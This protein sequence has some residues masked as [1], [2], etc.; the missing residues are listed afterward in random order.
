VVPAHTRG[1]D[2]RRAVEALLPGCSLHGVRLRLGNADLTDK[3]DVIAPSSGPPLEIHVDGFVLGGSRD[4]TYE[5]GRTSAPPAKP[6]SGLPMSEE[7]NIEIIGRQARI[8][9]EIQDGFFQD[10]KARRC[11]DFSFQSNTVPLFENEDVSPEPLADWLVQHLHQKA[12]APLAE[13]LTGNVPFD[14]IDW[15]QLEDASGFRRPGI[16][17]V[18][19]YWP[20]GR[21][22]GIY[23]GSSSAGCFKG[24]LR[25]EGPA[26]RS[27]RHVSNA[28]SI[29]PKNMQLYISPDGMCHNRY[30]IKILL[31]CKELEIPERIAKGLDNKHVRVSLGGVRLDPSGL[32]GLIYRMESALILMTGSVQGRC[33][34]LHHGLRARCEGSDLK[35]RRQTG[36]NRAS[37]LEEFDFANG[38]L[39]SLAA[40]RRYTDDWTMRGVREL[41]AG[42]CVYAFN[43]LV[44]L[45][46]DED[47][48]SHVD[49]HLELDDD[50]PILHVRDPKTLHHFPP[51]TVFSER[52][53]KAL[54]DRLQ[55]RSDPDATLPQADRSGIIGQLLEGTY[56]RLVSYESV[57]MPTKKR[58]GQDE[59]LLVYPKIQF[60]GGGPVNGIS[61]TPVTLDRT[62]FRK[63]DHC[64][65]RVLMHLFY[66]LPP[67]VDPST[68]DRS[69]A[70]PRIFVWSCQDS[71]YDGEPSRVGLVSHIPAQLAEYFETRMGLYGFDWRD[72]TQLPNNMPREMAENDWV[73]TNASADQFDLTKS[74]MWDLLGSGRRVTVGRQKRKKAVYFTIAY[75][76]C[77]LN[78]DQTNKV[79]PKGIH[80][81]WLR[82]DEH[83]TP[84]LFLRCEELGS[85]VQAVVNDA[86]LS[87]LASLSKAAVRMLDDAGLAKEDYPV[88]RPPGNGSNKT[89]LDQASVDKWFGALHASFRTPGRAVIVPHLEE[90][91]TLDGD[92]APGSA[93]SAS[94]ASFSAS[95]SQHSQSPGAGSSSSAKRAVSP[96]AATSLDRSSSPAD[97]NPTISLASPERRSHFSSTYESSSRAKGKRREVSVIGESA[98]SVDNSVEFMHAG[99]LSVMRKVLHDA[100]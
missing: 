20:D 66:R 50:Q 52:F 40:L 61:T 59:T 12:L 42:P 92:I 99:M 72:F 30:E 39:S 54:R 94:D 97:W 68:A 83:G 18:T 9:F 43:T 21:V 80:T 37:G 63:R 65:N 62:V 36:L 88:L 100:N 64:S 57:Y 73:H 51:V 81:F 6:P 24:S 90:T 74:S 76:R 98:M 91:D 58:E 55:L 4:S 71:E 35:V 49:V 19:T 44:A 3:Y 38:R 87:G 34:L 46:R 96:S 7:D 33:S 8:A 84:C 16:Y 31:C 82:F 32:R 60:G 85:A 67:G 11:D 69:L 41:S 15:N 56:N 17:L 75:L 93:Y 13:L 48:G 5:E 25:L 27:K 22:R 53:E 70:Q 77:H 1:I 78:L 2:V 10:V 86:G 95:S 79:W 45:P 89:W 14:Q 26:A 47:Y 28:R 23:V 29:R